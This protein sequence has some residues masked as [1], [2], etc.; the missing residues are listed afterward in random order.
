MSSCVQRPCHAPK[1]LF[2]P[3]TPQHLALSIFSL[4]PLWCFLSLKGT[5]VVKWYRC[6]CIPSSYE[7]ESCLQLQLAF[8]TWSSCHSLSNTEIRVC[9]I[10]LWYIYLIIPYQWKIGRQVWGENQSDQRSGT[11]VTSDLPSLLFLHPKGL[12]SSLCPALLIPISLSVL[13]P[14]KALWLILIR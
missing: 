3:Q 11:E 8:N 5:G 1:S 10:T 13:S 7:K 2:H 14:P 9:A 12:R 4:P 6:P